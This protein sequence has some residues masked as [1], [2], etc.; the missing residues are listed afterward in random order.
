MLVRL[1]RCESPL[2]MLARACRRLPWPQ[3]ESPELH[4]GSPPCCGVWQ[5][6][7]LAASILSTF[8]PPAGGRVWVPH[9]AADVRRREMRS[10]CRG[11]ASSACRRRSCRRRGRRGR[12]SG[13]T[14]ASTWQTS[15]VHLPAI[16]PPAHPILGRGMVAIAAVTAAMAA[17]SAPACTVQRFSTSS[18]S[19]DIGHISEIFFLRCL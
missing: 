9:P 3:Y 8:N 18:K 19:C 15:G 2:R 11:R 7:R 16:P 13:R 10:A 4:A 6:G 5:G 14:T 17:P 12:R 1:A